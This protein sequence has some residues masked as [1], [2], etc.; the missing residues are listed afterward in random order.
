M[1]YLSPTDP[2]PFSSGLGTGY[3]GV[4]TK[5]NALDQ[6]D[7]YKYICLCMYMSLIRPSSKRELDQIEKLRLYSSMK[8]HVIFSTVNTV[9]SLSHW[10]ATPMNEETFKSLTFNVI[11]VT[12]YSITLGLYPDEL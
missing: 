7:T 11:V 10:A 2:P 4:K 5:I 1:W 8:Q 3:G 6:P 9:N 12:L